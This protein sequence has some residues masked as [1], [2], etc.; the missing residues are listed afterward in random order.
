[1]PSLATTQERLWRGHFG[2]AY[3]E[4]NAVSEARLS[5]LAFL[6]ATILRP[7]MGA[8]P[9]SILEIGANVGL[10]LR[11]LARLTGAELYAVEP[12]ARARSALV[13]D[14]VVPAGRALDGL[15]DAVPLPAESMDLV[16]TSGVLIHV[17]PSN[18]VASCR[19]IHRVSA[20]YVACIEYFSDKPEE[21]LYRGQP[22]ALFKRDFGSFYLDHFDDL[23]VLDCGFAWK[24]TTGL[25]NLTWWLFDKRPRTGAGRHT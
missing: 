23:R 1:M 3:T 25:D 20:R 21:V 22:H 18:L 2:D 24:R 8:P 13:A 16:F 9:R 19:E 7:T 6:W 12:N 17:D 10:N 15:C 4:R 14:G 5:A 11:A